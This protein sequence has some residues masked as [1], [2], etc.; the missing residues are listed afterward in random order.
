MI[1]PFQIDIQVVSIHIH[2][3]KTFL[4]QW[5]LQNVF[6]L[7]IKAHYLVM[8]DDVFSKSHPLE[9]CF[10]IHVGV[11]CCYFVISHIFEW[12]NCSRKFCNL[13]FKLKKKVLH[14]TL[15]IH[16]SCTPI[17]TWHFHLSSS[18]YSP[19]FAMCFFL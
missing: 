2:S 6:V 14:L 11:V 3:F 17:H 19:S 1:L 13:F 8:I 12:L 9:R 18:P 16:V 10:A 7:G 15:C 4:M 5:L